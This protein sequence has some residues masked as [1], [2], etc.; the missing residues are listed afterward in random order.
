MFSVSPP[1]NGFVFFLLEEDFGETFRLLE[2]DLGE[3]FRLADR[4]LTDL[5]WPAL[6]AVDLGAEEAGL[7]YSLVLLLADFLL[8]FSFPANFF[9]GRVFVLR[10]IFSVDWTDCTKM[11]TNTSKRNELICCA[12]TSIFNKRALF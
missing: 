9:L 2:T 6:K 3:T 10:V 5:G 7:K 1:L 11:L 12:S 4:A 8:G